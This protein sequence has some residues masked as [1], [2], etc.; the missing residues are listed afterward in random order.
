[1]VYVC[2]ERIY[3]YRRLTRC[4]NW[5]VAVESGR[6]NPLL[7]PLPMVRRAARLSACMVDSGLHRH[8]GPRPSLIGNSWFHQ[9]RWLVRRMRLPGSTRFRA[10]HRRALH[11][12]GIPNQPSRAHPGTEDAA[13]DA[14]QAQRRRRTRRRGPRPNPL[15]NRCGGLLWVSARGE[16]T[17]VRLE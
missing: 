11:M 17:I 5:K 15:R 2:P 9:G 4:H 13:T 12:A 1:M 10:P 8:Q 3:H 16:V 7:Q 6:G 14:A